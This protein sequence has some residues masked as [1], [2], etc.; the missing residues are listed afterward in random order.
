MARAPSTPHEREDCEDN[1]RYDAPERMGRTYISALIGHAS[2]PSDNRGSARLG[3]E[4]TVRPVAS[5]FSNPGGWP[6]S[7]ERMQDVAVMCYRGVFD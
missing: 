4:K 7:V 1:D 2:C 6:V 5:P 3:S